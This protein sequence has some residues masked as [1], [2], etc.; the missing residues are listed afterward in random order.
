MI[1]RLS[2][3]QSLSFICIVLFLIL[4]FSIP[5]SAQN[6]L[7][8]SQYVHNNN[9]DYDGVN[10]IHV[11]DDGFI[12]VTH[13]VH[14]GEAPIAINT[15]GSIG[16]R[17]IYDLYIQKY[18]PDGTTLLWETLAGNSNYRW[19]G[20]L[21][22]DSK[23]DVTI[24]YA[25]STK[26]EII[27]SN[28]ISPVFTPDGTGFTI[29]DIY[30]AK[31]DGATGTRQWS[32]AWG[33]NAKEVVNDIV[34]DAKDNIYI[35][36]Y[37]QSDDFYTTPGAYQ[38]T[39]GSDITAYISSFGPDGSIRYSTLVGTNDDEFFSFT[40]I[41]A[42]PNGELYAAG[43]IGDVQGTFVPQNY[44][45]AVAPGFTDAL[46]IKL[47]ADG[48]TILNS[49]T[50]G[51]TASDNAYDVDI[52]PNGDIYI[53]GAT[54]IGRDPDTGD[55]IS[56]ELPTTAN[57]LM[58]AS[59]MVPHISGGTN[60]DYAY[61]AQFDASLSTL[62]YATILGMMRGDYSKN[63]NNIE[64]HPV[65]GRI[66]FAGRLATDPKGLVTSDAFRNMVP[67]PGWWGAEVVSVFKPE[68]TYTHVYYGTTFGEADATELIVK[69]CAIYLGTSARNGYVVT[70]NAYADDG[71]TPVSG[72]NTSYSGGSYDGAIAKLNTIALQDNS[73]TDY[74]TGTT[75]CVNGAISP[76][77]GDDASATLLLPDIQTF[78]MVEPYTGDVDISYMWQY[79]TSGASG[80][81]TDIIATDQEDFIPNYNASSGS[82]WYRRAAFGRDNTTCEIIDTL[83]SNAIE[84]V[85]DENNAHVAQAGEDQLLCPGET[86]DLGE[87]MI[88]S[89]DGAFPPYTYNWTPTTGLVPPTSGTLNASTDVPTVQTNTPIDVVYEL[90]IIDSRG[91]VSID[92]V[93]VSVLRAY[94]GKDTTYTCGEPM[95]VLGGTGPENPNI[96]SYEWAPTT[97]L[98]DATIR[99]PTVTNPPAAGATQTYT[100]TVNGCPGSASST[101]VK[102]N[103]SI[104]TTNLPTLHLCEGEETNLGEGL[105]INPD[106]EYQWTNGLHIENTID[107]NTLFVAAGFTEPI[108]TID[109]ALTIIDPATDC[110]GVV[111]QEVNAYKMPSRAYNAEIP[112]CPEDT[113]SGNT[114]TFGTS[115]E[116]GMTYEWTAEVIPAGAGNAVPTDA[117]ALT[118]LNNANASITPFTIPGP[119]MLT[120]GLAD[121]AYQIIYRRLSYNTGLP[122]C[123]RLDSATVNYNPGENCVPGGCQLAGASAGGI[124]CGGA[125]TYIGPE[126]IYTSNVDYEWSPVNGLIDPITGAALTAGGPHPAQV[127][128]NPSVTTTY[129]LSAI[130]SAT[131]DGC[132]VDVTVYDPVSSTP[133]V[134]FP[135]TETC[136]GQ[137]VP[138]G[139]TAVVGLEYVWEP[140]VLLNN[141]FISNPTASP[142]VSTSFMV[143]VTDPISTC[144]TED[145]VEVNVYE[146]IAYAGLPR[147]FCATSGTIVELGEPA[148]PDYTYEW[149]APTAGLYNTTS[150]QT[151][152][153]IYQ[154]TTYVLEV[155]NPAGCIAR[156]TVVFTAQSEPVADPGEDFFSCDGGTI[157]LGTPP[158]P[159]TNYT[160]EWTSTSTGNGLTPTEAEKPRP[161]ITTTGTGPWTY[162]LVVKEPGATANDAECASIPVEVTVATEPTI[163]ALLPVATPC[164]PTGVEI[165]L[166][167]DVS[168][169]TFMWSPQTGI[170]SG[171]PTDPNIFVYPTVSTTYTLNVTSGAGCTHSFTYDV[172][173][174]NY[175]VDLVDN[176]V[177]CTDDA[178]PQLN[179]QTPIPSGATVTWTAIQGDI[180]PLSATNVAEPMFDI[181]QAMIGEEYI[182]QIDVDEGNG[183]GS[184]DQITITVGGIPEGLTGPHLNACSHECNVVLGGEP[185]AG[186]LYS[187]TTV[188]YDAT[189]VSSISDANASQ[190]T[191]CL[192]GT[193]TF[194]LTV[195]DQ[196]T[197]CQRVEF[198][199]VRAAEPSPEL[200][201]EH[202]TQCQNETGDATVDL[203]SL[204]VSNT[205][206]T[207]SFWYDDR[208]TFMPIDDPTQMGAGTFYIKT[209]S[210]N[211]LCSS[212]EAVEVELLELPYFL[213]STTISDC[214]LN[215]GTI[216]LS[217]FDANSTYDY[218]QGDTYSGAAT[219]ATATTI[220]TN[221]IIVDALPSPDASSDFD[222]YTI[223]V[224]NE[225]DCYRD[226]TVSLYKNATCP[227]CEPTRCLGATIIKN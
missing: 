27:T 47:S 150:S 181:A 107:P 52:G 125:E 33:G 55:A 225:N 42:L 75:F 62:K 208:A 202:S 133:V 11:D 72:Y 64:V 211:G 121:V 57:A 58:G 134:N 194:Q 131:G 124:Y 59:E 29:E 10:D 46:V 180:A 38:T 26:S 218:T 88:E 171:N 40:G 196:Y 53:V 34:V 149:L 158:P 86:L 160:Y 87:A 71:T 117:E 182:Y 162:T 163:T 105:V 48:S 32:S 213:A 68:A 63:I 224:F 90:E 189:V 113:Y 209:I 3:C 28:G 99:N 195:I 164:D 143:T 220:P 5:L 142:T 81:W 35:T 227:V 130:N 123:S 104:T 221:G 44:A 45:N 153:T 60:T 207:T 101:V 106:Y 13:Y 161:T 67:E 51:G 116:G 217:D 77:D 132:T 54:Q 191:T 78:D 91:C 174:P 210:A 74:P 43:V 65:T 170:V 167:E 17:W 83:F 137:D 126:I 80:P 111:Y 159:G 118:F 139:G 23:G 188:P 50:F 4:F 112:W 19:Y 165:G 187:W 31:F 140:E 226:F 110:A 1:T 216:T 205:G 179:V 120:G 186:Y 9:V 92:V 22:V 108:L 151:T 115:P 152:D 24:A 128:A 185:I 102:N 201:V 25:S 173:G 15:S 70:P 190:I 114:P 223:R 172:D 200:T 145:T 2:H 76:I 135:D 192:N 56:N 146:P 16:D 79:S 95:V 14:N 97:G 21:A 175:K 127:I 41:E 157:T 222:N 61:V 166:N 136:L 69:D 204:I 154:T 214:D 39:Y 12:Y 98:D 30:I 206:T 66:V 89:P 193:T 215:T 183:C 96:T 212:I 119:T 103:S 141:P 100:L 169:W 7:Q 20:T 122:S 219:F 203:N 129:I 49:L 176:M 138:I 198:V 73:L 178:N 36:G 177:V 8:W 85:I 156:D 82:R 168:G 18:S 197:G 109:Y 199:M 84:V 94:A 144:Y 6:A 184:T 155:T 148:R 147:A 93:T 37:T